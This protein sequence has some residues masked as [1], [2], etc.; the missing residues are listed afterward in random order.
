VSVSEAAFDKTLTRAYR[1]LGRRERTV[2][3]MRKHLLLKEA[4]EAV[5]EAVLEELGTQGYLDDAGYAQRFAEDRLRLDGWGPERIARKLADT[6]VAREHVDRALA[7]RD[8]ESD[9][10]TA[11]ELLRRRLREPPEDDRGRERA[12]GFLVRKGYA[13]ELAYDAV[14]AFR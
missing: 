14:R 12:L 5:V 1:Y 11:V 4:D 9:L 8:S 6:G 3:E 13:L 10:E 2:A 7:G